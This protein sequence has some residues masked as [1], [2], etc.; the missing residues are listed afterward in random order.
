MDSEQRLA[1]TQQSYADALARYAM[2]W[3]QLHATAGVLTLGDL[4]ALDDVLQ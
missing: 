3:L 4:K 2:T 1:M